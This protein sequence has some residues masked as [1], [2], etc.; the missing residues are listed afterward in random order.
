MK[1][2]RKKCKLCICLGNSHLD[3][4]LKQMER[5]AQWA[6]LIEIRL[7]KLSPIDLESLFAIKKFAPCPLIWTLRKASQGG[8]FRGSEEKRL[9][10]LRL[11]LL[12]IGPDFIDIEA[13]ISESELHNLQCLSPKTQWIISWHDFTQTPKDLDALYRK[14]ARLPADY[15]KIGAFAQNSTDALR[16]LNFSRNLN[17]ESSR[18]LGL[19]MG[20]FGQPTRILAPVA[21]QPFTYAALEKGK[22]MAPGQLTAEELISIYNFHSLNEKTQIL[23]LI[24]RP[25]D[26]SIGEITHNAVLRSLSINRD[27]YLKF[28]LQDAEIPEFFNEIQTLPVRGLSVTMPF[29]EIVLQFLKSDPQLAACNTLLW[30]KEEWR[31]FNTDSIGAI[32]ALGLASLQD[33]K[34]IILGAGGTAKAIARAASEQGAQL[35]ILNRTPER[36]KSIAEPL[37][38]KWEL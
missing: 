1:N 36:A 17:R 18:F 14:A 2:T 5:A 37:G 3:P 25:V 11:L 15:Y 21:G 26:K 19:C 4:L 29:K 16:M 28:C 8:D 10:L 27:V 20:P 7:D 13:D 22:E 38:A 23:G 31:G 35:A 9:E 12:N 24:G 34:I 33:Q 30:T 6:D 32:N